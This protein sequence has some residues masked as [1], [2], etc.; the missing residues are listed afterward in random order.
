MK[1]KRCLGTVIRGIRTPIIKKGDNL[2]KITIDSL[3]EAS[4]YEGFTFNDKDIIGLTEGIVAKAQGNYVS[5][6]EIALDIKRKFSCEHLGI[7]YP[8]L[9]RNRFSLCLKGIARA[10]K[11]ITMLLTY[12][13][14]EVGNPILAKEKMEQYNINPYNDIILKEKY[15][16]LFKDYLHPFTGVNMVQVYQ[17]IALEEGCQIEFVFSNNPLTILN[18]TKNVL[19]SN[20]HQREETKEKIIQAGAKIV[21]TLCDIMNESINNSG[22]NKEYGLL[23]SNKAEKEILKLFPTEAFDIINDI[24]KEMK[25]LTGKTLEVLVY[26]DGAFK[27]PVM[28][29]WELADPVVSPFYTSGLEGT[30]N[31][32]KLKYIAD[33]KFKNLEG[34]KLQEAIKKE[35]KEKKDNLKDCDNNL[36]TTPRKITD[37]LGSLCDLTSGSGDKGTPLVLIQGYFDDYASD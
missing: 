25:R 36:G 34:L 23:G 13:T 4:Q 6:D 11:K 18:Y 1:K 8:I 15:D 2:V 5:V 24:Q 7:V 30:P 3:M 20:I 35:I 22:Y 19:V 17:D 27:D 10:S 26:G 32:I 12:P 28:G 21:Y 33:N 14:D 31:E 29:I 9:S 16:T 37:L